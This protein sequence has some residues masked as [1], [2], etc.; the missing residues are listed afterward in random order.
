MNE[1]YQIFL[2]VTNFFPVRP[3][4]PSLVFLDYV[5]ADSLARCVGN[6]KIIGLP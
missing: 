5:A 3:T 1:I 4:P 6:Q 2:N